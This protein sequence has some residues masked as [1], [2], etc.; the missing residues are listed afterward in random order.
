M[1]FSC[2]WQVNKISLVLLVSLHVGISDQ[3]LDLLL[4]HPRLSLEHRDVPHDVRLQVLELVLLLGLHDP[5]DVHLADGLAL[6]SNL[7]SLLSLVLG[8]LNGL[9]LDD[10]LRDE[11]ASDLVA[12]ILG[13]DLDLF[14]WLEDWLVDLFEEDLDFRVAESHHGGSELVLWHLSALNDLSA[15]QLLLIV[16]EAEDGC[17][18]DIG[19]QLVLLWGIVQ[20]KLDLAV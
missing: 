14:V 4:D 16:E 11:V 18:E 13:I 17:L 3:H 12:G 2:S 7:L 5:H 8:C 1:I 6:S 19:D 20:L 10:L 9:L 15:G